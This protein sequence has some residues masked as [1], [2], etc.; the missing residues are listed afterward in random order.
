MVC[1][2]PSAFVHPGHY[3]CNNFLVILANTATFKGSAL[4]LRQEKIGLCQNSWHLNRI[5]ID[6]QDCD[7]LTFMEI[8]FK[9]H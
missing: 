2:L 6:H 1:Q 5:W 7:A 3:L 8:F 4:A 9:M